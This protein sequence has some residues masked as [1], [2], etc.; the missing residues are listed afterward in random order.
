[1]RAVPPWLGLLRMA[2]PKKT[3]RGPFATTTVKAAK[4]QTGRTASEETPLAVRTSGL[5][6]APDERERIAARVGRRLGKFALHIERA[7][8][9]LD[10]INGPKGGTDKRCRI[11][12]TLSGRPSLVVEKRGES[13]QEA[14][15]SAIDAMQRA[16]RK[17]LEHAEGRAPA[18]RGRKRSARTGATATPVAKKRGTKKTPRKV[19]A[20]TP[21]PTASEGSRIGRGG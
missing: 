7:T 3:S 6:L 13:V 17:A 11:K 1:M 19:T 4:R 9:R 21:R 16:V 14:F 8:V 5:A 10:D 18:S 15:T 2:Q 12:V 20:G